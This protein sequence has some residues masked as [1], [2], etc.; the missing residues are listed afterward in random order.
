MKT[1]IMVEGALMVALNTIL[2]LIQFNGP[3]ING[4]S[5]TAFSMV[6]IC[7]F[8]YRHGLKWGMLTG[9]VAGIL[10]LMVGLSSLKGLTA[11]I[12]VGAIV[13][14]YLLAYAL[15][16][17]AGIFKNRIQNKILSIGLG[18]ALASTLRFICHVISGFLLWG[19]LLNDGFGAVIFSFT[20]N[21]GYMGPEILITIL[22]G[23][24]IAT[25]LLQIVDRNNK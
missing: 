25:P 3:W 21:I 16:G 24:F 15:L 17:F 12:F 22:G 10:Q 7:L 20:Y 9:F 2:S 5:V 4:G 11:L 1:R 18:F 23:I 6:P 19:S 14:D 8:A 13:L